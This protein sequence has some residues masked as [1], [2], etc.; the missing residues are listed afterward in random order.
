MW[1]EMKKHLTK[2]SDCGREFYLEDVEWCIHALT[3]GLGSKE[4]PQCHGCI[5]NGE[6]EDAIESRFDNNITKG[7]FVPCEPNPFGWN[8]M[9]KTVRVV[10][11]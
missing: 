5:C 6:T 4:C 9:C 8:H 1:D 10:E 3:M 2:C 7:K 11:V